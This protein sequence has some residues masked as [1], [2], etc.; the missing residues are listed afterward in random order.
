[1]ASR[2]KLEAYVTDASKRVGVAAPQSQ[3]LFSEADPAVAQNAHIEFAEFAYQ[4][5]DNAS[6]QQHLAEAQK[7]GSD[8]RIDVMKRLILAATDFP[9]AGAD[10]MFLLNGGATRSEL[11]ALASAFAQTHDEFLKIEEMA[12]KLGDSREG[13]AAAAELALRKGTL[14][15]LSTHAPSASETCV[16]ALSAAQ[17][18][19]GGLDKLRRCADLNT[20]RGVEADA[21]LGVLVAHDLYRRQAQLV[22]ELQPKEALDEK[23]LKRLEDKVSKTREAG[24]EPL[25]NAFKD[26][27]SYE[28]ATGRGAEASKHVDDASTVVITHAPT[29]VADV[30]SLRLQA[31]A[32]AGHWP[33]AFQHA[34]RTMNEVTL[35]GND[36]A[37]LA[38]IS[39]RIALVVGA[40]EVA[41]PWLDLAGSL[42]VKNPSL[43]RRIQGTA[44]LFLLPTIAK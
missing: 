35:D 42:V 7:H 36:G 5:R 12:K 1:M 43:A 44:T 22:A 39:A 9:V 15:R 27:I 40:R 41:R 8:V 20:A 24:G 2:L 11:F 19:P 4:R 32:A 38:Y 31:L 33:E 37:E 23:K 10:A 14:A 34:L 26:W 6:A 28:I 29:A 30:E 21:I 16:M 25:R 13:Q 17:N 3:T 18:S